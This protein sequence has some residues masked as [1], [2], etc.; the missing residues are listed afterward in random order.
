MS[1]CIG[2]PSQ[3]VKSLFEPFHIVP[4]SSAVLFW[5]SLYALSISTAS[6]GN[7]IVIADGVYETQLDGY[8]LNQI[9]NMTGPKIHHVIF[10]DNY[11][12]W[13]EMGKSYTVRL[14]DTLNV[15]INAECIIGKSCCHPENRYSFRS[16]FLEAIIELDFIGSFL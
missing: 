13:W 8:E 2:A 14:V 9:Y 6:E 3:V 15:K 7:I 12:V 10:V 4:S 1:G 16:S 5:L 11:K